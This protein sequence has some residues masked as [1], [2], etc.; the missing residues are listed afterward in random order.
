MDYNKAYELLYVMQQAYAS[1]FLVSNKIQIAGDKYC[2]PFTSR[3]FMAMLAILHI[4]DGERSYN[5][6]AQ[7]LG[8]TKQNAT[9]LIKI[10]QK[11]GYVNI[12]QST[13][14][15]R[16]VNVT[17]TE[18]GQ[19]ALVKCSENGGINLMADLFK[20]F[21]EEEI[22][23]FWNLLKKLY[24]FDGTAMDGFEEKIG[25]EEITVQRVKDNLE[26]FSERRGK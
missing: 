3:Q 22:K 21:T 13:K 5:N 26:K 25:S 4:N 14:D 24:S 12:E 11:N 1:L 16:S 19:E 8:T 15:K 6:I 9:Q 20:D 10:L 7:K 18:A 23:V 2:K 17:I